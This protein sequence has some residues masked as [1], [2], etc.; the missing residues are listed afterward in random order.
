MHHRAQAGSVCIKCHVL[1]S[2]LF[3][4]VS[5]KSTECKY[6]PLYAGFP[7]RNLMFKKTAEKQAG[8]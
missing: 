6:L 1:L 3:H 7:K 4:S 2:V 8:K 5:A